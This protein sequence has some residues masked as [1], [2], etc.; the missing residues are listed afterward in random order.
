MKNILKVK[1][2][3]FWPGFNYKENLFFSYLEKKGL[4]VVVQNNPDI[5]I[6]SEYL[7]KNYNLNKNRVLYYVENLPQKDWIFNYSMSYKSMDNKN[8]NFYNFFYYPYFDEITSN[9]LSEVYLYLKNKPKFKNINFIY[10]NKKGIL[11]NK[12]FNFL[13][14]YKKIDSYGRHKNNMGLLPST[15]FHFLQKNEIL[16]DYKYTVAFENSIGDGYI[17]EKIWQPLCLNSIPIYFGDKSVFNIFNKKKIIYISGSND[18]N[19]SLEIINKIDQSNDLY[20]EILN[21]SIFKDESTR[22]YY[23]YTN[24]SNRFLK[25]LKKIILSDPRIE[26]FSAKFVNYFLKS[27]ATYI[28]KF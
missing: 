18:F 19:K 15:R 22:I 6:Y 13:S 25:F 23:Q 3:G 10:T 7:T 21:E 28:N 12:Y 24:L 2:D 26:R 20:L 16:S 1:F 4:I 11:R 5:V 14:K 17:S 27:I 9:N 8:F